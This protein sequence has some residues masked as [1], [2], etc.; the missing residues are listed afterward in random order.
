MFKDKIK[1]DILNPKKDFYL[2][3][4]IRH[5]GQTFKPETLL[6]HREYFRI[7]HTFNPAIELDAW[8]PL[9]EVIPCCD[10]QTIREIK[11]RMN[12]L[13]GLIAECMQC[14]NTARQVDAQAELNQLTYY[15]KKA[16]VKGGKIFHFSS[17][18]NKMKAA[19]LKAIYRSIKT[20]A[21]SKPELAVIVRNSLQIRKE[22][23]FL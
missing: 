21:K 3:F 12:Y 22:I 5:Q 1:T 19:V 10:T 14:G 4:L 13:I 9:E 7:H 15:L 17:N 6:S 8:I 16:T 11:K 23:G 20:L 2:V 18:Y